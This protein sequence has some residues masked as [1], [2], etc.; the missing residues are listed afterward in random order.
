MVQKKLIFTFVLVL[1]FISL[2][3]SLPPFEENI[4]T[5]NGVQIFYPQYEYVERSSEFFLNIH[6]S[7][8]S[9]GVQLENTLV[10]C[11]LYLYNSTGQ[12]TFQSGILEKD[13]D[14]F[15]HQIFLASGNF[16][17]LGTHAFYIWCNYSSVNLGGEVR[18][19]FKVTRAGEELT[20]GK[21][22]SYIGFLSLLVF[23]FLVLVSL[24]GFLPSGEKRN[25]EGQIISRGNLRYLR[26]I[27]LAVAYG[28]FMSIFF[29]ASNI[30]L[31]YFNTEMVGQFLFRIYLILGWLAI[32]MG[33]I[34]II[35]IFVNIFQDKETKNMI[36]RG[37]ISGI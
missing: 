5:A 24:V 35:W 33:I 16:S 19:T 36:E 20:T 31:G 23:M 13:S 37:I 11:S 12:N 3:S 32:P 1:M 8:I 4:G 14:G 15:S 21:S 30:A 2:V 34:W 25:E 18:G 10:N 17:D 22:I 28:I 6:T 7:N 26:A 9:N 29:I 27:F